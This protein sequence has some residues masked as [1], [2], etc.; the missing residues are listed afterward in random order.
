M[1]YT[2]GLKRKEATLVIKVRRLPIQGEVLVKEGQRVSYNTVVAKASLPGKI[3]VVNAAVALELG[4]STGEF[5]EERVSIGLA[6]YMLKKEG[7]PVEKGEVLA[8]RKGLFGLFLKECRSPVKGTLEYFSDVTGQ[9]HVREPPVPLVINA[10]IPGI[11][12]KV[13]PKEGVMIETTAAFIQGI[14]G[15]GGETHGELMVLAKSPDDPLTAEQVMPECAGKIVVGGSIVDSQALKKAIEFGVKGV[16]VGG[17]RDGDLSSFLGYDIGVAITGQESVGLTLILTEG[18]GK[19]TMAAKTFNL[20]R[21][22]EGRLAC[23]NGATQIRAGV[24]RP[25]IIIPTGE[26]LSEQGEGE[27]LLEGL[28]PGLPVRI[29]GPPYFGALGKVTRLPVDLQTIETE[30]AVRVLEVEL[31]DGRRVIVPRANVEL[32]EE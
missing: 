20:L 6:K 22:F 25:E 9:I 10:Y 7:D 31:D 29:I 2:P 16:V 1:A 19:M 12:T 11:V 23:I 21:K 13:F 24:I 3:N 27:L 5:E 17:I 14:F 30:S 26:G 18:F 32:I 28:K 15:V 4:T 8:R